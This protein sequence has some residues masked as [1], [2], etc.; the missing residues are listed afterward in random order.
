MI[1]IHTT[2]HLHCR[3]Y[4][5]ILS[6]VYILCTY[7]KTC[8]HDNTI[9]I[10]TTIYVH[11]NTS[12]ITCTH[13]IMHLDNTCGKTCAY[14]YCRVYIYCCVLTCM[15]HIS[16]CL[17]LYSA[18]YAHTRRD[19][20]SNQK[21]LMFMPKETYIYIKR[22]VTNLPHKDSSNKTFF[23]MNEF[24]EKKCL[25]YVPPTNG[26]IALWLNT[27]VVKCTYYVSQKQ[28]GFNNKG[29]WYNFSLTFIF[30]FTVR[31]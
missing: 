29:Q 16:S 11:V 5:C 8:T 27:R 10:H 22:N 17:R 13:D 4:V 7:S 9:H 26:E 31:L 18:E 15:I 20:F 12:G 21:R 28:N 6:R 30:W 23:F 2:I 19:L 3:V 25:L 24:A 1:Y 14:M